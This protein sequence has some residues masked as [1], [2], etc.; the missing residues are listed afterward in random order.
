MK[1]F[2]VFAKTPR[3]TVLSMPAPDAGI[4]EREDISGPCDQRYHTH[5]TADHHP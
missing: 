5:E 4:G 2:E 1:S 3:T